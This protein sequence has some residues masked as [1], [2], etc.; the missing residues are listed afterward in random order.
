MGTLI[1]KNWK[2]ILIIIGAIVLGVLLFYKLTWKPS[3]IDEYKKSD[4]NIDR[5][6]IDNMKNTTNEVHDKIQDGD[7]DHLSYNPET[8]EVR[9]SRSVIGWIVILGVALVG[10]MLLDSAMNSSSGDKKKK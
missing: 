8:G 4:I 2:K 5:D 7:D 9:G 10:I 6:F 3:V 1:A